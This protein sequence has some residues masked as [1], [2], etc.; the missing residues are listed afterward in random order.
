M[1]SPEFPEVP[2]SF[3][4][5]EKLK[6]LV[7]EFLDSEKWVIATIAFRGGGLIEAI[8]RRKDVN[9]FEINLGNRDTMVP[10]IL[11]EVMKEF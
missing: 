8:K 3:L 7:K 11:R 4:Y 10:R 5:S 2:Y 1:V 9:L 6:R